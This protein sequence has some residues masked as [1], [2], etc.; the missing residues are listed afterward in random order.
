MPKDI[1]RQ[2]ENRNKTLEACVV[3]TIYQRLDKELCADF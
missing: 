1:F 3:T 2:A